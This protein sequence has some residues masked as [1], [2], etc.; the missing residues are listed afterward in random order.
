MRLS[1][2]TAPGTCPPS[3]T[4]AAQSGQANSPTSYRERRP[5]QPG[6]LVRRLK[7]GLGSVTCASVLS[8]DSRCC[9]PEMS[10]SAIRGT[11][12]ACRGGRFPAP[13]R[14]RC[15][16][17]R[18]RTTTALCVFPLQRRLRRCD[19]PKHLDSRNSAY[20]GSPESAQG[21]ARAQIVSLWRHSTVRM[22]TAS[23]QTRPRDIPHLSAR[24]DDGV[25]DHFAFWS[26]V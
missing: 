2:G 10:P 25:R 21:S 9:G 8:P 24:S 7:A 13:P 12:V 19:P 4:T 15:H 20:A 18:R 5:S 1:G 16:P 11:K 17:R 26:C 23:R 22:A 6:V 14:H 3:G